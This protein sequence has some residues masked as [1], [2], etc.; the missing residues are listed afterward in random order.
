[1]DE[2]GFYFRSAAEVDDVFGGGAEKRQATTCSLILM[3]VTSAR[4][5]MCLKWLWKTFGLRKSTL[6]I[7]FMF[8]HSSFCLFIGSALVIYDLL[9]PFGK[10]VGRSSFLVA[11][12]VG[13][14]FYG[15]LVK[16]L[17]HYLLGSSRYEAG[18]KFCGVQCIGIPSLAA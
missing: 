1:V 7:F 11:D 16:W 3:R 15:E 10:S 5:V 18:S 6:Y 14:S 12:D 8:S 17:Y 4:C 13:D 2:G 9:L